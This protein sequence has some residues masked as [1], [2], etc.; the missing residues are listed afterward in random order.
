MVCRKC[1]SKRCGTAL[2]IW[3]SGVKTLWEGA[4]DVCFEL[5]EG[6]SSITPN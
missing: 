3:A 4:Q 2:R 5:I 6:D 1:S